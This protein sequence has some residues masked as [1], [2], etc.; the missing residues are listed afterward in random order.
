MSFKRPH[1]FKSERTE[2][3]DITGKDKN[4]L[5]SGKAT[6]KVGKYI[7][8]AVEWTQ[9]EEALKLN[10]LEQILS[11]IH[12]RM[13]TDLET[14]LAHFMMNNGALSL[15]SPN[16]PIKK[17]SDVAQTASFIKDIGIKTSENY[18]VMDPWSAQRLA[19]AQTTIS[20]EPLVRS[21]WENAQITG[22]FGG[23]RALMSNGLASRE[24]G[25][26][27]GTITVKTAP[28]VDYLSVKDSYQ[29][30]ITLTGATPSKTGFL[31]AGD[32]LKFTST[33][34]L[35]QQSKQTLYNGSTAISFTATVLE[36][37]DS[38]SSG[39]VTVKLSGVPIY[40]EKN[41][42]YNA[43]DAKVKAG[44][45]VSIIGTAKQQM[46]PNLFYNKF[47]L[48]VRNHPLAKIT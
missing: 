38:T 47:F 21:A 14:E 6:G 27:D 8:V 48:W 29:F 45:A 24:Q 36:E 26:F 28:N 31:K 41:A 3:G 16:T 12:E 44:D 13:V 23:I 20:A 9:I 39:D 43:V 37:T 34:W 42:Q 32:Q 2:T 15:G 11:P 46:K 5:I 18:A 10:Q 30:T 19:D 40:D 7:T 35:N 1:Q 17:W 4:G 25:D 22:N 33:H